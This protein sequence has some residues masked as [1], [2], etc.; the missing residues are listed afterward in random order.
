MNKTISITLDGQLFHV[1]EPAYASLDRYL[2]AVRAHFSSYPDR[3]EIVADIESRMAEQFSAKVAGMN[4]VINQTDIDEIIK[5][6]GTVEDFKA[7]DD[8]QGE[9][10]PHTEEPVMGPKRKLYRDSDDK[11]LGGVAS[12]LAAY[13]GIDA[14]IVRLIF[15]L[16]L[17]AGGTGVVAYL[18]LWLIVPEA[19]TPSEKM[20]MRG[21]RIT[22]VDLERK[23]RD[24]TKRAEDQ[25]K[26]NEPLKAMASGF[27]NL[28]GKLVLIATKIV[29]FFI[30]FGAIIA[31][32]A[33]T[34]VFVSLL[35]NI[36]S[37]YVDFPWRGIMDPTIFYVL[38][39]CAFVFVFVPLQFILL[40]GSSLL[41]G[42]SKFRT[43]VVA[44]LTA[45]WFVALLVGGATALRYVPE[46]STVWHEKRA[47]ERVQNTVV[48]EL[49][50][51]TAIDVTDGLR[52]TVTQSDAFS[53]KAS[54]NARGM[55]RLVLEVQDGVLQ[56]RMQNQD[57]RFCL[58]CLDNEVLIEVSLPRVDALTARNGS[59]ID[60]SGLNGD[61]MT[62]L[63]SGGSRVEVNG[64]T[65]TLTLEAQNGSRVVASEYAAKQVIVVIN[66]GS[67]AD[68]RATESLTGEVRNG[69]SLDYVDTGI[70]PVVTV[71]GG[72]R[73]D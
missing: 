69:S 53:V 38:A 46:Y 35:V 64:T 67:R 63:S 33:I 1:E 52:T 2:N 17:F 22:I 14:T 60:A 40:A 62:I 72:S 37:P 10:A 16:T 20:A 27:M 32:F 50:D 21:E 34:F 71:S 42:A 28:I 9:S 73:M 30:G 5:I 25:V 36:N 66:G 65:D 31:L 26:K 55:E 6:M 39:T 54:G 4:R 61:D 7:F 51:F 3:D 45:L 13:F 23:F 48:Y 41:S 12:G 70:T 11:I 59:R 8:A 57:W 58:F 24:T 18:I 29:G 56:A 68:V 15:I 43:P 49:A 19:L 47:E 44:G